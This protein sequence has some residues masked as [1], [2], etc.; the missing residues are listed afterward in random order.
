MK[1]EGWSKARDVKEYYKACQEKGIMY[2]Q[3][4][5]SLTRIKYEMGAYGDWNLYQDADGNYWESYFS[6]GD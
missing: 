6:I 5:K 2:S 4:K 3:A 1:H